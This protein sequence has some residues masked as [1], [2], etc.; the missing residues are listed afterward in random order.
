MADFEEELRHAMKRVEPPTGFADAVLERARQEGSPIRNVKAV[1]SLRKP[2]AWPKFLLLAASLLVA[3][4]GALNV[5]HRQQ[6]RQEQAQQI[7]GQFDLAI[8]VTARTLSHIDDTISKAGT[9]ADRQ[10]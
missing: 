3:V 9:V 4:G 10:R 5:H 1:A 7:R 6:V 8:A 2:V